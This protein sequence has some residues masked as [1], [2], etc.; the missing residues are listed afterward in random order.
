[1]WV[2]ARMNA[3]IKACI[4]TNYKAECKGRRYPY[5]T[6]I[7]GQA[8][9]VKHVGFSHSSKVRVVA[10]QQQC[11]LEGRWQEENVV[12]ELCVALSNTSDH[13]NS[14]GLFQRSW[15]RIRI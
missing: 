7:V 10:I 13:V 2:L 4:F 14:F 6:S 1:M 3:L 15:Y 8:Y 12:T 5:S 9:N 11:A